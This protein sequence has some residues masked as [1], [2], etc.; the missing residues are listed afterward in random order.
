MRGFDALNGDELA[1]A[2]LGH[3][4]AIKGDWNDYFDS[5]EVVRSD[6]VKD[7]QVIVIRLEKGDL[8]S[9]MY[10]IDA[11]NGDVL[12]VKQVAVAGPIRIPV[13]ITNSDFEEIDGIRTAMRVEIANP[14]TGNTI[15]T[16]DKIESGLDLGDEVF[17]LEDSAAKD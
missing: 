2:L 5:V 17:T 14:A 11:E 15:L 9:R 12:V 1:Q 10:W 4:G 16:V 13:T 7:R 8:P 6:Q 3:P